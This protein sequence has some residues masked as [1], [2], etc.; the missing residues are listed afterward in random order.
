MMKLFKILV[1]LLVLGFLGNFVWSH[2]DQALDR[3]QAFISSARQASA[4]SSQVEPATTSSSSEAATPTPVPILEPTKVPQPQVP[5]IPGTLQM[6]ISKGNE[7]VA[8]TEFEK[9]LRTAL[10]CEAR[11]TVLRHLDDGHL[12]VQGSIGEPKT[13]RIDYRMYLLF[14][15]PEADRLADGEKFEAFVVMGDAIE[16]AGGGRTRE[17]I[18]VE[19]GGRRPNSSARNS[20]LYQ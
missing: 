19:E 14:G 6:L 9:Y 5:P 12:L 15:L 11:G 2:K 4:P 1:V 18:Y 10:R 8:R 7:T 3:A 16:T 13:R 20:D 17:F